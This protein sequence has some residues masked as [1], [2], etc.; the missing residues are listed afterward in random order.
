MKIF[1]PKITRSSSKTQ[2][3][4]LVQLANKTE[5]TVYLEIDSKYENFIADDSTAAASPFVFPSSKKKE[6]LLI[7]G[8]V[9]PKWLTGTEKIISRLQSWNTGFNKVEVVPESTTPDNRG[10]SNTGVFFS[11]GVDSFSSFYKYK[12]PNSHR[13]TFFP[14]PISRPSAA[15]R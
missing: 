15:I 7:E 4:Y 2:I 10:E 14:N 5:Y 8:S 3:S 6:D 12:N 1:T 13:G 9:S 11:A